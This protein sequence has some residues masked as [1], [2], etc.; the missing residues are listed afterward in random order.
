MDQIKG[1]L[2]NHTMVETKIKRGTLIEPSLMRNTE[3][4][5]LTVWCD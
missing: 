5:R 4:T 1:A 2:E 3:S